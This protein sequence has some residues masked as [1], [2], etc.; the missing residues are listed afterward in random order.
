MIGSASS[1]TVVRRRLL[2]PV[3]TSADQPIAGRALLASGVRP[4]SAEKGTPVHHIRFRNE[5][6]NYNY[7]LYK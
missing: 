5:S 4:D 6:C 7:V 1:I 2:S 3:T